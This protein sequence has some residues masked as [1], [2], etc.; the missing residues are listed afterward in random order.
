M[1]KLIIPAIMAVSSWQVAAAPA[2]P[3][4]G[5]KASIEDASDITKIWDEMKT[6]VRGKDCYRRAQ[7]W[8]Y[9][10]YRKRDIKSKKIFIHYTQK[11]NDELDNLGGIGWLKKKRFK[12][13]GISRR[14]RN[15]VR[16]NIT[17]DYH[18]APLVETDE[19]PVVLDRYLSLAYDSPYPY[20]EEEAWDLKERPATP[21]E[22]VEALT[23]RGELLWQARKAKL[24]EDLKEN[25]KKLRKTSSSTKQAKYQG[26]I[27]SINATMK[28]LDMVGKDSIDIKCKKVDSI[29]VVDQNHD[30][31]WCFYTEAPMYYYNE[32]DLRNL[33]YGRSGYKH[34]MQPPLDVVTNPERHRDG[35]ENY[36]QRQFNESELDDAK[37]EFK[38]EW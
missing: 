12:A 37:G 34:S 13:D 21:E 24:L 20:N 27:D 3:M 17:W 28:K 36:V 16:S 26:R 11:W 38:R 8:A 10:M 32:I 23:V 29:Y 33:A 9:D 22:W 18:V 31:A 35:A 25:K 30:T 5:Y 14:T 7:I 15:M 2:S 19:G 6:N 4:D 1:K